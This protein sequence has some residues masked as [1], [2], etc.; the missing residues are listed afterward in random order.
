[1]GLAQEID[2][3]FRKSIL[4]AQEHQK[5][6]IE[7]ALQW[8]RGLDRALGKRFIGM[9][10]NEDTLTQGNEVQQGLEQLYTRAHAAGLI[11]YKPDLTFI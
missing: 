5:P 4:Y 1:M 11:P 8:G 9:Y 3:A 2:T 10:V 6:A 7:Y